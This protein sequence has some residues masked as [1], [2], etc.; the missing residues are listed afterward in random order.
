MLVREYPLTKKQLRILKLSYKFRF[1]TV[2][3]LAQHLGLAVSTMSTNI[4]ILH[5]RE[6]LGRRYDKKYK[7]AGKGALSRPH[8]LQHPVYSLGLFE[9]GGVSRWA[10]T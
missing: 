2:K 9:A 10:H 1:V 5:R 8:F 7:L 6:L 4:K 3:L